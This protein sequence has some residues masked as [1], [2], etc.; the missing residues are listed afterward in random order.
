MTWH[1]D[2]ATGLCSIET[3]GNHEHLA[4][5]QRSGTTTEID[6]QRTIKDDERLADLWVAVPNKVTFELGQLELEAV[7]LGNDLWRLLFGEQA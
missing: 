1:S 3:F 5:V 2:S 6:S 7:H 4:F